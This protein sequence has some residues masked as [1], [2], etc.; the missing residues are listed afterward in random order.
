MIVLEESRGGERHTATQV[1]RPRPAG[2][3][4][5]TSS[6]APVFC[7]QA[8]LSFLSLCAQVC[9]PRTSIDTANLPNLDSSKKSTT[10]IH[11]KSTSEVRF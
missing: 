2:L 4:Y 5:K 6:P 1:G 8:S 11:S 7:R 10:L 3:P 9:V